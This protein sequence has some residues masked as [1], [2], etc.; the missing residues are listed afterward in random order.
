MKGWKKRSNI[1]YDPK[2]NIV[3]TLLNVRGIKNKKEFL[4]PTRKHLHS[5]YLLKNIE[6]VAERI[7]QAVKRGELV[8]VSADVDP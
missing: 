3:D 5:P 6:K 8:G 2:Q 1:N 4:N 7:L